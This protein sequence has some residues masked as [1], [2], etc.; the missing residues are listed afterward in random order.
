MPAWVL[1]PVAVLAYPIRRWT[2][3]IVLVLVR[4]PVECSSWRRKQLGL[5]PI[6]ILACPRNLVL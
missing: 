6:E 1:E 4:E 5:L 3:R 2:G